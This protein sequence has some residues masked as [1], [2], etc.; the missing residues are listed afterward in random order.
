MAE[1]VS[2]KRRKSLCMQAECMRTAKAQRQVHTPVA[3]ETQVEEDPAPGPSSM[4]ES[5]VL[6]GPDT[7]GNSSSESDSSENSNEDYTSE[8][9]Q[10]DADVAYQAWVLTLDREDVKMMALML[11]DNYTA[12]FGLTCS[13]AAAEVALLLGF[14]EKT[15][16]IWRRDF[17]V[18]KG[19]FFEYRRGSYARY[20]VLRDEEYRDLA[21]EWFQ[22]NSISKRSPNLT[23]AHFKTWINGILLPI[24]T[25]EHHPQ[26]QQQVSV[27]TATRWLHGLGFHPSQSH[28]GVY[29][30]GHE[31]ADVVEYRKLYL[32]KLKILEST[33]APPPCCSDDPIRVRQEEDESKK[34]LVLL[35]YDE[36]TFH[37]NDGQGWLWAEAGKQP[38]R[39]NGQGRGIMVSDFISEHDGFL[40]LSDQEYE[41]A[42]VN[43]PGL[44]K[45][46]QFMLRYGSSSVGYWNSKKFLIQVKQALTIAEAKYPPS[47]YSIVFFI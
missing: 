44:W 13:A 41:E 9:C 37:F 36:S 3:L 18:N 5:V 23:A 32:R 42:H 19:E 16:R 20:A 39:P 26:I 34:Q 21:L 30:D 7:G 47:A 17:F 28:K 15:I 33:H 2:R 4:N 22:A 31:R 12:R 46:A 25:A 14:N 40:R 10:E 38:T 1:R 6:P 29:F 24:V 43:H 27:R 8:L 35:Y 45:D 11:H